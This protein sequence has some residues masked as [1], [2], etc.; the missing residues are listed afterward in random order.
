MPY[1]INQNYSFGKDVSR[2]AKASLQRKRPDIQ[3]V[4]DDLHPRGPGEGLR[5]VCGQD[6]G[7]STP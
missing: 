4:G 1:L 5:T 7:E 6:Q 2:T 3:I